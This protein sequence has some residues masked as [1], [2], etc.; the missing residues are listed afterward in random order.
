MWCRL[1]VIVHRPLPAEVDLTDVRLTRR[2]IAGGHRLSVD[3]T[4]R[5]PDPEP[6]SPT[7]VVAGVDTGW[8][9]MD[10]GSLRVAVWT[11]TG[12]ADPMSD[13][14]HHVT[15][16]IH[17]HPDGGGEVRIPASWL[18]EW[19]RLARLQQRRDKN[20][21]RAATPCS[22]G[23]T[24]HTDLAD[25]LNL[26]PQQVAMWRSPR[27][28]AAVARTA[29]DRLGADHP[30]TRQLEDWRRH[31][32]RLWERHTH[33]SD[34]L[35]ARRTDLNRNIAAH[36]AGHVG[37]IALKTGFIPTPPAHPRRGGRHPPGPPRAPA[38]PH[39]GPP[40]LTRA[41]NEAAT[42][43]G[44]DII[45]VDARDTSSVHHG[46]GGQLDADARRHQ[47]RVRC[48]ACGD[49][50]DQ[51]PHN[52][53]YFSPTPPSALRA[54][55]TG[56]RPAS[57]RW[58]RPIQQQAPGSPLTRRVLPRGS[59]S[60]SVARTKPTRWRPTPRS[61]GLPHEATRP[62]PTENGPGAEAPGA[63]GSLPKWSLLK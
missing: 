22:T 33:T 40:S 38:R 21:D 14:P 58:E 37:T 59:A 43:R 28:L 57:S 18:A 7:G 19:E 26:D 23:S 8:R 24:P 29:A 50:V 35:T 42:N 32:R 62:T 44:T 12:D 30:L 61:G 48:P 53:A 60:V 63:A 3:V 45:D 17:R 54:T 49:F 36:L 34:Q 16:A 11:T 31:D 47:V 25:T 46:C 6:A 9:M 55:P 10:D 13:F 20:F 15:D 56:Q 4:V 41:I 52:T 1:P 39:R 2:R 51:R 5:L 27:R